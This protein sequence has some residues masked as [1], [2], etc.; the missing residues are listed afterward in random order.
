MRHG[1]GWCR[2]RGVGISL[3]S[4]GLGFERYGGRRRGIPREVRQRVRRIVRRLGLPSM[5]ALPTH[6]WA[7]SPPRWVRGRLDGF[8]RPT[9]LRALVR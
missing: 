5:D 3:G 4:A 1:S 9:L 2:F 6:R 7:G 8:G